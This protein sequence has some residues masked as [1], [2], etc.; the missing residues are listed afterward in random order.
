MKQ[1]RWAW[2]SCDQLTTMATQ[3]NGDDNPWYV[4]HLEYNLTCNLTLPVCTAHSKQPLVPRLPVALF[5][6]PFRGKFRA[7][8]RLFR[9][10]VFRGTEVASPARSR[11]APTP[12]LGFAAIRRQIHAYRGHC[13][14]FHSLIFPLD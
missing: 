13:L 12:R 14:D 5:R 3:V 2:A 11:S 4:V 7:V 8:P 9:S 10:S 6:R 1:L